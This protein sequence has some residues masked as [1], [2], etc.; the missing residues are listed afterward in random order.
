MYHLIGCKSRGFIIVS[1]TNYS[2]SDW[3]RNDIPR[4]NNRTTLHWDKENSKNKPIEKVLAHNELLLASLN[5]P[6][7]YLHYTPEDFPELHI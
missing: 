7:F 5:T 3:K 2:A 1:D 4:W 6:D